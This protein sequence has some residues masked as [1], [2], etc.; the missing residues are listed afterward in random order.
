M[1]GFGSSLSIDQNLAG[2]D[3]RLG[4]LTGRGKPTF[5]HQ[6]VKPLFHV[7]AG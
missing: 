3:Q 5:H 2:H 1:P 4:I 7:F 6:P